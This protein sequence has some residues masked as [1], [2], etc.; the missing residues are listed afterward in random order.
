MTKGINAGSNLERMYDVRYQQLGRRYLFV[1]FF[2]VMA[3]FL[4]S[5]F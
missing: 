3:D 2:N 5:M 1:S 4:K